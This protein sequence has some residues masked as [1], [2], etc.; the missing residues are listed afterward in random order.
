MHL[1]QYERSCTRGR[2]GT[3]NR[4]AETSRGVTT[5]DDDSLPLFQPQ[6]MGCESRHCHDF[7]CPWLRFVGAN[8]LEILWKRMDGWIRSPQKIGRSVLAILQLLQPMPNN[9]DGL[10]LMIIESNDRGRKRVKV[11]AC[12]CID[13]CVCTENGVCTYKDF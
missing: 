6:N 12:V 1:A 7:V 11:P 4:R 9:H 13:T 2:I 3:L 10:L 8:S 5:H